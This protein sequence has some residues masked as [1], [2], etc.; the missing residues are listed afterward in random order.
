MRTFFRKIGLV[1]LSSLPAVAQLLLAPAAQAVIVNIPPGSRLDSSTEVTNFLCRVGNTI[2]TFVLAIA[3]IMFLIAAFYFLTGGD[4]PTSRK[5]AQDFLL[6]GIIGV[7]V[8][9]L[10]YAII[11]ILGSIVSGTA[12]INPCAG[13]TGGV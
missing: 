7:V 2:F 4:N 12:A 9:L 11:A 1:S 13:V 8:A 6:Y 3:I 10:P 5:R